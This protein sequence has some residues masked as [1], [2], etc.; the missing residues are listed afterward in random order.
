MSE[1]ELVRRIIDFTFI[2]K[3]QLVSKETELLRSILNVVIMEAEDVLEDLSEPEAE[4]NRQ[5]G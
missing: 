2:I 1:Q 5:A 4:D 3:G